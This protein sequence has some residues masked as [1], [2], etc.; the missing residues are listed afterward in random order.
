MLRA[1]VFIV[2]LIAASNLA[3]I[4]NSEPNMNFVTNLEEFLN[5]NLEV[6]LLQEM[7]KTVSP[8]NE[9]SPYRSFKITY[10]FG[11]RTAC[12]FKN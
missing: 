8:N 12:K 2:C 5:E 3:D 10:Q 6:K 9:P 7:E 11:N 4:R 1:V